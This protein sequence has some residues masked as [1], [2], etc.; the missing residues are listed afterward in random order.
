MLL[1]HRWGVCVLVSYRLYRLDGAG[2]ISSAEWIDAADDKDA[3][4]EARLRAKDGTCELWDRS[5]LIARIEPEQA[6]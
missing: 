3:A 5:R 6:G 2:K 4:R 1:I